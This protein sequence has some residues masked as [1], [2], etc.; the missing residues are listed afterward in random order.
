MPFPDGFFVINKPTGA[1]SFAMVALVRRLTGVRRVGHAGTLDPLA[2]GV[3]PI[4][5]GQATR[6]IEYL[7]DQ[8]KTYRARIR[9][10]ATTDTYDAE[11]NVI[12]TADASHLTSDDVE[13]ALLAFVGW[14]QQRPP[15]FSAIKVAG[16]PMYKYARAGEA[17]DVAPRRV[18][19]DAA[20]L[21]SYADGVADV[22][23]RCA[24]G[25]YVR[26]IAHDLGEAVGTGAYLEGLIRTAS[27]GFT[28]DDARSPDELRAV[29][30]EGALV[31]ALLAPD[32]ALERMR[33]AI[34]AQPHSLAVMTGGR[35]DLRVGPGRRPPE[36]DEL[37][38]AYSAGGELLGVLRR[39]RDGLWHPEKVLRAAG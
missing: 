30:A 1:T 12:A 8:L 18:Y 20:R 5:V 10:G 13:A 17:P 39:R 34:L 7:D 28:L 11:G 31:D 2:T 16:K 3:L 26:S 32:R 25:T 22:E 23:V 36:R 19:V 37:C 27:G 38:R 14:I 29:A 15:V 21:L 35:I 6:L 9:F 33:A 4:A 24:K